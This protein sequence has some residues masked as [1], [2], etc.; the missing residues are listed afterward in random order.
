MPGHPRCWRNGAG[1][2]NQFRS[3]YHLPHLKGGLLAL[4]KNM[5]DRAMCFY[6]R[7]SGSVLR[8]NCGCG[9]ST[10]IP[11][12]GAPRRDDNFNYLAGSNCAGDR[13]MMRNASDAAITQYLADY[14]HGPNTDE[15]CMPSLNAA[16]FTKVAQR[17]LQWDQP[18]SETYPGMYGPSGWWP[19]YNEVL[20][21][22]WFGEAH[23]DVPV[24]AWFYFGDEE[25]E[26]EEINRQVMI[27]ISRSYERVSGRRLPVLR[28]NATEC[29][30]AP[31]SCS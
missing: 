19:G 25:R 27:A 29:H 28:I 21:P 22:A 8:G 7:D 31:F 4:P 11:A 13:S 20:V 26:A 2:M 16:A 3:S 12:D 23:E 18:R 6:P 15:E 14:F 30:E 9:V 10:E 24:D 1:S 17:Q 5:I